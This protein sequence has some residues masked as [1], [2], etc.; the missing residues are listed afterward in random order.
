VFTGHKDFQLKQR[1]KKIIIF[2]LGV[3]DPVGYDPD[4]TFDKKP[5]PDPTVTK[6]YLFLT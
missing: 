2:S 6:N 5:G 3:A 4:P 1:E